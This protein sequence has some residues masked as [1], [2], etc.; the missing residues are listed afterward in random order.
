[1][2]ANREHGATPPRLLRPHSVPALFGSVGLQEDEKP[3][4]L[5]AV[6]LWSAVGVALTTLLIWLAL[7]GEV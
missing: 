2:T 4:A 5:V 1:M 7:G 6:S 3:F